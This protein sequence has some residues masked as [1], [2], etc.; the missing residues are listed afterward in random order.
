MAS[1]I[2]SAVFALLVGIFCLLSYKETDNEVS[3]IL[4][5]INFV[6]VLIDLVVLLFNI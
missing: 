1:L 5:T 2:F 6:L 4:A 3:L